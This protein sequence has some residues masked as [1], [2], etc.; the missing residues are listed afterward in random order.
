LLLAAASCVAT[1]WAAKHSLE[2]AEALSYPWRVGN[3]L[4][5]YSVYL[6]LTI[7]P[8][9]MAVL[10]PHQREHLSLWAVALSASVLLLV[11]AAVLAGWR[12]RP[13]LLV[14]WLW[15]IGMLVPVIGLMQVGNQARADRFTY[16]PQIGLCI[17]IAWSAAE[18]CGDRRYRRVALRIAA[19][20]ILAA[21]MAVAY[22]QTKYWRDSGSLWS[23]TIGCTTEN[24]IAH[25]NYG[26]ALA[27]Q[28]RM[29]EAIQHYRRAIELK[30]GDVE[31]YNNLGNRLA[32]Q[33]KFPEAMEQYSRA[34]RVKPDDAK[35]LYNSGLTLSVQGALDEAIPYYERAIQIEP[36][37]IEAH[38]NLGNALSRRGRLTEAIQHYKRVLQLKPDFAQVHYNLANAFARQDKV[39]EAA[40]HYSHALQLKPD[41]AESH[42][43]W[44]NMLVTHGRTNE[45]MRHFRQALNLASAQ[46][47]VAVA[48]AV[49]ARI[50]SLRSVAEP[51]PIR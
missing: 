21:L 45:A 6:G 28:G 41:Y 37:Y 12:K 17:M 47:N 25:N 43:N 7:Y 19:G 24:A 11:S 3:A 36:D 18:W 32:Q 4:V 14:G 10:Y 34:L 31:A 13:Y 30:P 8:A 48:A 23:H 49:R 1:V 33:G 50:E 35:A 40:S 2:T 26:N 46:T 20:V 9:G 44:G 27:D 38:N 51:P 29:D 22:A 15:Y 16:L 39:D 42:Y 5:S